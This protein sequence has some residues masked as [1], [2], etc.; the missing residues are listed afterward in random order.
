[1]NKNAEPKEKEVTKEEKEKR[2]RRRK[3]GRTTIDGGLASD[4]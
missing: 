2:G 1:V 4:G 3:N